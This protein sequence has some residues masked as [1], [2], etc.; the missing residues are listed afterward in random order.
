MNTHWQWSG[1]LLAA[2]SFVL[3]ALTPTRAAEQGVLWKTTSRTEIA[4]ARTRR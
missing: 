1:P 4:P 2:A 3:L